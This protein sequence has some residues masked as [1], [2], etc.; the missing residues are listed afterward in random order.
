MWA[1]SAIFSTF[2]LSLA[3]TNSRQSKQYDSFR[4]GIPRTGLRSKRGG[5]GNFQGIGSQRSCTS[6]TTTPIDNRTN[7]SVRIPA[8]ER[9][10]LRNSY[11]R[12][13]Q[14]DRSVDCNAVVITRSFGGAGTTPNCGCNGRKTENTVPVA[15]DIALLFTWIFPPCF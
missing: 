7:N 15:G 14:A 6:I 2:G 13:R 5:L 11:F 9:A 12:F 8:P 1:V 3:A 10:A 4:D